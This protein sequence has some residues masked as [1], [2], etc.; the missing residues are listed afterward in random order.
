MTT[1]Q[2]FTSPNI[3]TFEVEDDRLNL[4]QYG[5][6][7]HSWID[8]EGLSPLFAIHHD[9][10]C[11]DATSLTFMGWTLGES[12]TGAQ[13][14]IAQFENEA[15]TVDHHILV[16]DDTTLIEQWQVIKVIEGELF[17]PRLD[18]Y[19]LDLSP[20]NYEL[21][22][23]N[24]DWGQEFEGK[25][26]TLQENMTLETHHGRSSKGQHPW[27]ALVAENGQVLS[28]SVAWSGNWVCRF[29]TLPTGGYRL[30]GGLHD[31]EY[32]TTLA[33]GESLE[34]PHMILVV[35]RDLNHVSQ[36]YARVGRQ[37]W[38]PRN[39]LSDEL[40]VE[41]NHWWSYEDVEINE[42]VFLKN[43]DAAAALGV[44]ICT[45]DA[46]WFGEGPEWHLERGDWHKVNRQRF[47]GGLRAL[48]DAIHA[49]GMK[50]GF[51]CEI[52]GLGAK[53]DLATLRPYFPALSDQSPLGYVC[54]GNP[55]V[56]EWA[57]ET[58][59]R[60][61]R[62]Y[63]CDWIKLDFNVDPQ[64]GCNRADHGHDLDNGLFA[65]YR[66]YYAVLERIRAAFPQ[67]V[68]ENC[69]SGGLR[70]DLGIMRHTHLTFLSDPD[71]PVHDLQVFWGAST[72][73]AANACL[74]WSFSEW[75]G[76]GRPAQQNFNPRD[77]EL[78]PHQLDYYT[79][80]AMLGAFGMSQ[81]LPEL[82]EWVAQ[83]L[84]YHIGMYKQHVRRYV[85][86]ADLYRL[87]EQP[88]RS[89]EGDGWCAFQ[90]SLPDKSEHLLFVFRLPGAEAAR[91]IALLDL[92]PEHIYQVET[93]D[94]EP[95][96]NI[97]GRELM[98]TGLRF[99]NLPEEGSA[100]LRLR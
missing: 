70:I 71:W 23:F 72:M 47:P 65:H 49:K 15:L 13:H 30:S 58:L 24:S 5:I 82:P 77:P 4:R 48:S 25:Q 56:Q 87:T 61:I 86:E 33:A 7:G 76:E 75:R 46:G 44:E 9:D 55:A 10:Q 40:P 39:T 95:L 83:R 18:S 3:L 73:L 53:A 85:R 19:S 57:F 22:H 66:G 69:S 90:Y 96:A 54:F 78:Q 60:I 27:F 89:G 14:W 59:S 62:E 63:N 41:W 43:V 1:Q 80:I 92:E 32:A 8:A 50:F 37:H 38:Y 36:Q 26:V 98:E 51:W 11:W 2:F 45:L 6:D 29:E 67:V 52:E 16:Y 20:A 93:L 17:I 74:H 31:W 68:L 99:D 91:S 84:A 21:L 97:S 79:R 100:L 42:D 64:A 34:T 28:G 35:G 88:R 94:G 81:K 12:R